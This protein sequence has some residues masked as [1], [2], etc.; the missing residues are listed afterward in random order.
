MRNSAWPAFTS[1][2]SLNR[3]CCRMP[4]ARARTWAVRDASTRPGNSVTS[5]T[6]PGV[7]VTTPTSGAG[8][9][10]GAPPAALPSVFPQAARS[11]ATA[12]TATKVR[13]VR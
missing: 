3:R 11:R 4:A 9:W 1:L 5:P 13:V 10:G 7:A 8:I 12:L 6:S 2:P